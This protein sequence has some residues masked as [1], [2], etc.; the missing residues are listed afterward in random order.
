[1]RL[2]VNG[3]IFGTT[4]ENKYFEENKFSE[5]FGERSFFYIKR[6]INVDSHMYKVPKGQTISK[7]NYGVLNSSKKRT[8]LTI[9]HRE[10]AQ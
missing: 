1:M 9:L 7:A 2:N 4:N 3:S 5:R 6:P 8:K 10:D